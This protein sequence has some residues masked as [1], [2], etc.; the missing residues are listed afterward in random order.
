MNQISFKN[1]LPHITAIIIFIL[2]TLIYVNPV[3]SGK[4]LKQGD[5]VNYRGMSKEIKDFRAKTGEEPLWTNSMFGGMPAYQISMEYKSNLVKKIDK[6]FRLGL[7]RPADYIFLNF[8]GFYILLLVLGVNPWLSIVGAF[9]YTF[10]SYFFIILD[11][12]HNSKAHAIAYMAPVIAGVLLTYKKKYILGAAITLLFVS[13]EI[14][15]NHLQITY[16]LIFILLFIGIAELIHSIKNKQLTH[17]FK[18]TGL[19]FIVAILAVGPNITN[20]LLTNQY[21]KDSIRGKSE[22]TTNIENKTSGLD[23]D[24]ATQ[25]SYGKQETLTLMIPNAKGGSSGYLG[26][27]IKN[28]DGVPQNFKQI[29]AQQNHYWGNQPFTSGPV[30]VGAII[31]F[32][33]ILGL[34]I[35]KT[36]LKWVILAATLLSIFLSWGHNMMWFS[37]IFFHYVPGYNKFRTVSMT[38]VIAELCIPLLAMLTVQKIINTPS[39]L[40]TKKKEFYI[41]F[42]LTGGLAFLFY[43]LPSTFFNFI[44]TNELTTFTAQKTSYPQSAGQIDIFLNALETVRINIFKADTLRSMFLIIISGALLYFFANNKI[45]TP[46]LITILGVLIVLDMWGIDKRYLNDDKFDVA[47]KIEHP[48]TASRADKQILQDTDPD[49]R[50]FNMTVSPFNDASTSYFHKSIGGYHGAKLRRYQDVIEHHISN[51][52]TDVL[53]MLNTKYFILADKNRQPYAQYNSE[54]LG[55]VWFVSNYVFVED[56]DHEIDALNNF[57]PDSTVIIDK[58]FKSMID[59]VSISTTPNGTITLQSYAPNK[60]VY[61]SNTPNNQIAV[62]SEIYYKDGW[63]AYVD[64]ELHPYFRANYILRGMVIPKGKHTIIFKFEPQLY[65]TGESIAMVSSILLILLVVAGFAYELMPKKQQ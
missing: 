4:K 59:S 43:L 56:A 28:L 65:T 37:D 50:V 38:L 51:N 64:D 26:E 12:G 45:K 32:L 49:F 3:L 42:G 25:W 9:A 34:L 47:R 19:L 10:S 17:F 7:P 23:K 6:I 40:K 21:S 55:H 5:I 57:K 2:T 14:A 18:A 27:D 13:L 24:Y 11:A 58:R 52:N 62:F 22:L 39:I 1:L 53:N 63:N 48:F 35:I 15:A 29:I 33:F 44:S 30:Y 46:V 36:R 41:A 60:L 8:I 16:Y 20:I 31:F 61:T 54:A